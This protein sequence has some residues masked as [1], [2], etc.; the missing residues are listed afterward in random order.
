[1]PYD[2]NGDWY[3]DSVGPTGAAQPS[4]PRGAPGHESQGGFQDVDDALSNIPILGSVIS[5]VFGIGEEANREAADRERRAAD[6]TLANQYGFET[7]GE[8]EDP[9]KRARADALLATNQS[10]VAA[11]RRALAQLQGAS[12]GAP[13]AID[14]AN[15]RGIEQGAGQISAQGRANS[16]ALGQSRGMSGGGQLAGQ[17]GAL[18]QAT[19][20]AASGV[21]QAGTEAQ[22]RALQA[23]RARGQL[24]SSMRR[25]G[26]DEAQ[27]QA[28]ARDQSHIRNKD[29]ERGIGLRNID[30]RN[31][32]TLQRAGLSSG[33]ADNY[34]QRAGNQKA[35]DSDTVGG[36]LQ[37]AVM[38]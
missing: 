21:A 15:M 11:Q 9:A 4:R 7:G 17:L 16:I 22:M 33:M 32:Q 28:G 27:A 26:F 13:D 6:W 29:Y 3:E 36:L 35:Q 38:A 10:D 20:G 18:G 14:A 25:S 19:Q 31:E 30:R 1:M 37:A 5:D 12:A 23:L 2:T 34:S 24:A 8:Y